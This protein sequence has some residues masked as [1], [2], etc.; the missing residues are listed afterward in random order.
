MSSISS[1]TATKRKRSSRTSGDLRSSET[2]S[3]MHPTSGEEA[4]VELSY[5]SSAATIPDA[6]ENVS[7][8]IHPAKRAKRQSRQQQQGGESSIIEDRV[9]ER[10]TSESES[11]ASLRSQP[12]E[13]GAIPPE[14]LAALCP[15]GYSMNPPPTDRPVRVYADGVFDLFHLG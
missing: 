15:T 13:T 4:D 11:E 3:N 9:R 12:A 8:I 5:D 6:R 10:R 1:D 14:E 2:M 7:T